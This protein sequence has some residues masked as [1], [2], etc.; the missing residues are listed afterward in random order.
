NL[1]R[2]LEDT[3]R[4]VVALYAELEER[5]DFLRRADETKSRFLSSMS[6]EFRTPLNSIRALTGLLLARSDGPLTAE[7]EIQLGFVAKSTADLHQLVDDLL[8][9]AKS[10]AGKIEV[11]P[12]E[13]AVGDLFS[14]LR[15]MLRPLLVSESVAL[16]FESETELPDMYTDE[17]KV[18][19]ILRN[20]IS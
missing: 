11:R 8:D 10:E 5:A 16:R 13:F 19:Q 1:N 18:S 2:E 14:A 4:G 20:L 3:N 9:L 6:H 15:G 7:Q 17:G 12:A